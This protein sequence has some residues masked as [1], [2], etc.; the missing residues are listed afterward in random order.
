MAIAILRHVENERDN[1]LS[2][3]AISVLSVMS[4]RRV[5]GPACICVGE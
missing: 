4:C 2:I 5:R 1:A 3:I